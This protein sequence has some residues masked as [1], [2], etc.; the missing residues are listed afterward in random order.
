ML[1]MRLCKATGFS[2]KDYTKKI[3]QQLN[4]YGDVNFDSFCELLIRGTIGPAFSRVGKDQTLD[5]FLQTLEEIINEV[6][7]VF[8]LSDN[9]VD[10]RL[11]DVRDIHCVLRSIT[12]PSSLSA[13]EVTITGTGAMEETLADISNENTSIEPLEKESLEVP[14]ETFC[15]SFLD[16]IVQTMLPKSSSVSLQQ[17]SETFQE[18]VALAHTKEKQPTSYETTRK[19]GCENTRM[20]EARAAYEASIKNKLLLRKYAHPSRL[21]GSKDSLAEHQKQVD[22]SLEGKPLDHFQG[23]TISYSPEKHQF[24]G[25][26]TGPRPSSPYRQEADDALPVNS[27]P[28]ERVLVCGSCRENEAILWCSLCFSVYCSSCWGSSHGTTVDFTI[29]KHQFVSNADN[30]RNCGT[31]DILAPKSRPIRQQMT[32]GPPVAI[33]YLPIKQPPSNSHILTARSGQK[34]AILS[35]SI[36]SP[37]IPALQVISQPL[38]LPPLKQTHSLQHQKASFE[39]SSSSELLKSLL[40]ATVHPRSLQPRTY[41]DP[42]HQSPLIPKV[43]EINLLT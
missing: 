24:E 4:W 34:M 23:T 30:S 39:N 40:K 17:S 18:S 11:K 21:N 35:H 36:S 43:A 32:D 15:S 28:N 5:I 1:L 3:R 8:H 37:T 16:S 19:Q 9:L 27:D 31:A 33:I 29:I 6:V 13:P 41:K 25:G 7:I 38:A 20:E 10:K 26:K 2:Y 14:V 42:K 22:L 12:P